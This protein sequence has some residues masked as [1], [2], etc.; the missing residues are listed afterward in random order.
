MRKF[1]PQQYDDRTG[2]TEHL[3]RAAKYVVSTGLADPGWDGT[4]LLCG[5]DSLGDEIRALTEKPG[6]DIVLT[7]SIT[8]ASQLL[9]Q[10]LIDEVRLFVY[11]VVLGHGRRL[12]PDGWAAASLRLL[13][14]RSI[15]DVTLLRYSIPH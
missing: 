14:Q 12:F 1:W 5:G 4:T 13:E 3:N 15:Q 11:P 2:V 8:L 6:R 9:A 7:G 10:D